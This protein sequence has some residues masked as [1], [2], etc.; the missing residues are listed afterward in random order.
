MSYEAIVCRV[1]TRPHPN[2]DRL[3]LGTAAGHQV[4]VGG[5]T[6]DRALGVF[7]PADGQLS[8]EY[9]RANKL[10]RADGGYLEKNRRI[11]TLKLRG[12]KSEGLWMPID[13]LSAVMGHVA[14]AEGMIISDKALCQKYVSPATRQAAKVNR[15]QKVTTKATPDFKQ[16]FSTP[17]ARYNYHKL[18]G[19]HA[20]ITEKLHGTSGRTGRL[21][22]R[23]KRT[24]LDWLL[25]RERYEYEY[26][27]GTRRTV[28]WTS[29]DHHRDPY[30]VEIHRDMVE[31]GLR[32][33]E[34]LYYE[35]V[36]YDRFETIMPPHPVPDDD[37]GKPIRE[38]YGN[39]VW[40][41]YGCRDHQYKVFVYRI[42]MTVE[43]ESF[44]LSWDQV[45]QRCEE[46]GL[47]TVPELMRLGFMGKGPDTFGKV[48]NGSD[49]LRAAD[50]DAYN[51]ELLEIAST[52]NSTL[53]ER[54]P[55][56]G[57]CVRIGD[58]IFKYKSFDF[59][60]L[61]GIAKNS[62]YYADPEEMEDMIDE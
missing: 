7:F 6:E 43:G 8:L 44:D 27:T 52:G 33:G 32:K 59:C 36:G 9:C 40:Y 34:T 20:V 38:Q 48:Y 57:V 62:D 23:Q 49:R 10:L 17:K 50:P 26:T 58:S 28:L 31:R 18:A 14:Y 51:A 12:E 1:R 5:D 24:W 61:E 37:A 53:D 35:I 4:I 19:K 29:G 2:A 16:H 56:E 45:Q 25:R 21:L 55:M 3:Q 30:R 15:R 13:S 60:H 39:Q 11:R 46:L 54:H 42:T 41:T 47:D 22:T